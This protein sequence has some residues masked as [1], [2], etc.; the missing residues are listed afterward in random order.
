MNVQ[1]SQ[2]GGR[3][4]FFVFVQLFYQPLLQFI[5]QKMQLLFPFSVYYYFC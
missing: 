5:T 2:L 1:F 4:L 3:P